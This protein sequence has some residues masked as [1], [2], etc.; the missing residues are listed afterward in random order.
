MPPK[1]E[2]Q[3][4]EVTV[5]GGS[6]DEAGEV[7]LAGDGDIEP[8]EEEN[9]LNVSADSVFVP[10]PEEEEEGTAT[11]GDHLMMAKARMRRQRVVDVAA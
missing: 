3:E 2:S 7:L 9:A 6:G 8:R 5:S 10:V 4:L 11:Q 1:A